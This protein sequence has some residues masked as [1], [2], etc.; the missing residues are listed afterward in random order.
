[1]T[2]QFADLATP[3]F[4]LGE[5]ERRIRRRADATFSVAELSA[6]QDPAD[7]RTVESAS[8]LTFGELIRLLE[9]P[10]RWAKFSWNLDRQ[11]F[12]SALDNVRELRNEVMHFNPDPLGEKEVGLLRSFVN[13]LRGLPN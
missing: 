7:K 1:M 11:T 9:E 4:L 5:I 2:I 10:A 13:A 8:D 3:F 12:L 6:M